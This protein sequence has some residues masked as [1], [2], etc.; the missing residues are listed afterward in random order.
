MRG[1]IILDNKEEADPHYGMECK[2][3]TIKDLQALIHGKLLYT[4]INEEEYA[5]I[6]KMEE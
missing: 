4:D 5:L 2:L 6:I 1:F 3:L